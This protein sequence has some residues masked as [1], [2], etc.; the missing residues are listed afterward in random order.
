MPLITL[1]NAHLS[2]ARWLLLDDAHF[3]LDAGEKVALIGRNGT[4]KSTLLQVLAGLTA[5]D[6]GTLWRD[7]AARLAYVPQEPPLDPEH[8]VFEACAEGLGGLRQ[9]LLDYHAVSHALAQPGADTDALLTHLQSFRP[10]WRRRAAGRRRTASS[11][12]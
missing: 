8:T 4:G 12:C 10:R 2:Y 7:G 5:L 9:T 3:S 6:S 11:R 1:D